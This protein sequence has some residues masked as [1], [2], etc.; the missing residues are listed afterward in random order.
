[1][2][3][4]TRNTSLAKFTYDADRSVI[5]YLD[6]YDQVLLEKSVIIH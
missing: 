6:D 4:S 2:G 1:M 3:R 5:V